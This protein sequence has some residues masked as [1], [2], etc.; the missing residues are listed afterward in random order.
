MS[1][2]LELITAIWL[3]SDATFIVGLLIP[4]VIVFHYGS[5]AYAYVTKRDGE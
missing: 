1:Y 2:A 3:S 5:V 4:P